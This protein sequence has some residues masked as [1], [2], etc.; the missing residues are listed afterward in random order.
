MES[1]LDDGRSDLWARILNLQSIA[2]AD[3]SRDAE[4]SAVSAASLDVDGQSCSNAG[5]FIAL[6]P[7]LE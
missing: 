7:S 2:V 5:C 6:L 4:G 3:A 1:A